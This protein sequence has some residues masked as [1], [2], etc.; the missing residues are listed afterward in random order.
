[1]FDVFGALLLGVICAADMTILI[2]LAAI[3]PVV[4]FAA[5][6]IAAA[7]TLLIFSI[8]ALGGF[9]SSATGPLPAPAIAFLI[10]MFGGLLAW[11]AWPAFRDAML[12]IPLAGLVGINAF[13]IGGICFLILHYRGRLAAPFATSAG[14]GDMI[15]DLAAI[16]LAGMAAW[17][18]KLPKVLLAVWNAFG[19]LDLI[20]AI[21]LGVLS[22]PGTPF[23]VFTDAPGTVAMGTLAWVGVPTLLVP[24]YLMTHLTIAVRLRSVDAKHATTPGQVD[25]SP[26]RIATRRAA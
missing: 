26:R 2:S 3:R 6:I 22:P 9:A 17:R 11:F 8:A 7:W 4:K 5:F 25:N 14:W 15:A 23:R 21:I 18:G 12:S 1:M 16:L 20:V 19:A 13:R 24:L 10:L